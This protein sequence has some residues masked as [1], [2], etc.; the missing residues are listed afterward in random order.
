MIQRIKPL[1]LALWVPVFCSLFLMASS[2]VIISIPFPYSRYVYGLFGILGTAAAIWMVLK[3]DKNPPKLQ[4]QFNWATLSN[5]AKGMLMALLVGG[6]MIGS[7]IWYSDLTMEFQRQHFPDFALMAFAVV[8]LSYM[9]ELAFRSYAFFRLEKSYGIWTAQVVIAIVFALYHM[10]GGW[11]LSGSFI[12]PGIWA[13]AFGLLALRSGGIALPTGFHSGLNL[14]LAVIG[15]KQ[16]IPGLFK[17]DFFETPTEAMIQSNNNFGLA[18]HAVLLVVLIL[19]TWMYSGK[20][21]KRL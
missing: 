17:V 18:L 19:S 7:Q 8:V 11:S 10:A 9:E 21:Q 4:F 20:Q 6:A 16:W 5:F 1:L 14:A 12:G 2:A 15:D 13:F 3:W